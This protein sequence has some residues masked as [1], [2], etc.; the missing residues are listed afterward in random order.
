MRFQTGRPL[1]YTLVITL[2]IGSVIGIPVLAQ[3]AEPAQQP[4]PSTDSA[5]LIPLFGRWESN[6]SLDQTYDNPYDSAEIEVFANFTA[7][8][9]RE[10]R[11]PGFF[12]QPYEDQCSPSDC[13]AEDLQPA[14]EPAWHIRF[15]PDEIGV[16]SY[17]IATRTADGTETIQSGSFDVAASD[18]PG[19]VRTSG[20][21]F[22]FDSGAA[23]FPV[24]ENLIWSSP[25]SGG[26]YA[27][28]RWLDELAAVGA[29]YARLNI[30]IPWFIGLEWAGPAGDY[31]AA[32][33]AAWRFDTILSMAETRGIYLQIGLIWHR[34]FGLYAEPAVSPPADL[35]PSGD[36]RADWIAHPYNAANGG[37]LNSPTDVFASEE[38]RR[39]LRQRL[40]YVVARWGYSPHIFAWEIVDEADQIL[41]YAPERALPLLQDMAAYL[42]EIDPNAHLITAGT[43]ASEPGLWEPLDFV[44]VRYDQGRPADE[45]ADQVAGVLG[46][47]GEA[48]AYTT[49]P[50]LLSEFSLN[51]W[52]APADDDPTGVHVHNTIWAAALGGFAG[53]AMPWWWDNYIDRQDLY[54]LFGPLALFARDIPWST[55]RMEP[56]N[57]ALVAENPLAYGPLRVD[58]FNRDFSA[59]SPPDVIY[60]LTADGPVPSTQPDVRLSGRHVQS[61]AQSPAD[62]HRLAP[63]CRRAAHP[64]A[65]CLDRR[66]GSPVGSGGRRRS[67]PRRSER[68]EPGHSDRGPLT[69]RRASGRDRQSRPGL[70][71][72]GLSG[73]DPVPRPG[74]R[75]GPGRPPAGNRR[76]VDPPPRLHMAA[77]Q[78]Q[79]RTVEFWPAT[80]RHAAGHLSRDV[81][82][83][84]QR[85]RDR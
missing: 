12:M 69:R 55:A 49:K 33:D 18:N 28:E 53:G 36:T 54:H 83:Y 24:G 75:A 70:A 43:V 66:T 15:T 7:P 35:P 32:Q 30:D 76:R 41:G 51:R 20:R 29:N 3:A 59:E 19:F 5:E 65:E 68:R 39:L 6:F 13:P 2:L 42:R 22:A 82:G 81:L 34:A 63:G 85:H 71:P 4:T 23:Y 79:P 45:P 60:R 16:W 80:G 46:V 26:I 52:Y 17:S 14:G 38:A 1:S 74:T 21:Y 25:E 58:N 67:R 50:M 72:V 8:S 27:Y 11:V 40:R 61:R 9:G 78:R 31:T 77:C 48:S 73:S 84:V 47:L 37:P 44:Q 62:L 10:I 57:V 56:V 64:C